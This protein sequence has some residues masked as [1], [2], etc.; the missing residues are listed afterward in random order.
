MAHFN[1]KNIILRKYKSFILTSF[2]SLSAM[3]QNHPFV[4]EGKTWT[5]E[6]RRGYVMFDLSLPSALERYVLQ[7]DTAIAGRT[8]KKLH[9][10]DDEG[11]SALVSALYEE[12]GRVYFLPYAGATEGRLLYDFNLT[13]RDRFTGYNLVDNS[14]L[15]TEEAYR[16]TKSSADFTITEVRTVETCG[17]TVKAFDVGIADF[18]YMEAIGCTLDPFMYL[19]KYAPGSATHVVE[20]SVA[21]EKIYEAPMWVDPTGIE[22]VA[23]DGKPAD[24]AVYDLSGRRLE[25]IPVRGIYIL[26][27]RKVLAK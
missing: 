5:M 1:K 6:T 26:N 27:G 23:A 21:S 22:R 14:G 8:W 13:V 25:R 3:A 19:I 18:T 11:K 12:N 7:G 4:E 17:L 10:I 16:K 20:C 2:L 24:G 9:F 15:P